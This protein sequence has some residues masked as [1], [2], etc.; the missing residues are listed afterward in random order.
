MIDKVLEATNLFK[1]AR[2]VKRN[3]GASGVDGMNHPRRNI[4]KKDY[5]SSDALCDRFK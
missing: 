3:K 1:A 4:P 2:Q 5:L